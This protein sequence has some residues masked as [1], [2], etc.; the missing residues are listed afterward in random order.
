MNMNMATH[1]SLTRYDILGGKVY[2]YTLPTS[3]ILGRLQE[4]IELGYLGY[5]SWGIY[6]GQPWKCR[7]V[8]VHTLVKIGSTLPQSS[9]VDVIYTFSKARIGVIYVCFSPTAS[10]VC[11]I[12]ISPVLVVIYDICNQ[13]K[14][15]KMF[16]C[17]CGSMFV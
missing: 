11:L 9:L 16:R 3:A 6:L 12:Y 5:L 8:Q 15:V 7:I 14:P 1:Q 4:I 13:F 10:M 2:I 17:F